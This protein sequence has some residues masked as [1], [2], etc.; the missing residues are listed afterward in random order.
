MSSITQNDSLLVI[1]VGGGA[2]AKE[3]VLDST[4]VGSATRW[5]YVPTNRD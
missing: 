4:C 1:N 2:N 3:V 5:G